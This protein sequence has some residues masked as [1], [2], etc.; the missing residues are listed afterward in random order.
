[1]AKVKPIGML[2]KDAKQRYHTDKVWFSMGS[3]WERRCV[4]RHSYT[5]WTQPESTLLNGFAI[6]SNYD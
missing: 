2:A 6:S 3:S 1:M 4:L 5:S